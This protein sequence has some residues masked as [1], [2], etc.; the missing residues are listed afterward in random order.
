MVRYEWQHRH[1][2]TQ[3]TRLIENNLP[4][5]GV[6]GVYSFRLIRRLVFLQLLRLQG[7]ASNLVTFHDS[8]LPLWKQSPLSTSWHPLLRAVLHL[9]CQ[10]TL[11]TQY[12]P[13]FPKQSLCTGCTVAYR[14]ISDAPNHTISFNYNF[15][16]EPN[17]L[18]N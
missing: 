13:K 12:C 3:P 14:K 4:E 18:L 10:Q 5:T 6:A 8:C 1:G 16:Y 9:H 11:V 7:H 15:T 17:T 2:F